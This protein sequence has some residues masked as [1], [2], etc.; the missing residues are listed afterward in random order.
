MTSLEA[1]T[2]SHGKEGSGLLCIVLEEF[3]FC[4]NDVIKMTVTEVPSLNCKEDIGLA[5]GN[6]AL[7]GVYF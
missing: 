4:E 1:P 3:N 2:P 5:Y 7:T 6:L